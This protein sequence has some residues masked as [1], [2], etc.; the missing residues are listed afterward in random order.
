MARMLFIRVIRA[1]RGQSRFR[2]SRWASAVPVDACLRAFCASTV[3]TNQFKPLPVRNRTHTSSVHRRMAIDKES[4]GLPE[5]NLA[6]RTTK[7]NL[8]VIVGVAVFLAAMAAVA[9]WFARS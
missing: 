6:R 3:T 4:S 5:V 7:V 8:G 9:F 2:N 1:I